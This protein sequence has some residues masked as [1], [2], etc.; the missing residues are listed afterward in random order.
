MSDDVDK[1]VNR[2]ASTNSVEMRSELS[3]YFLKEDPSMLKNDELNLDRLKVK[4]VRAMN[5][6]V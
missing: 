6:I 1:L 5:E 2:I 3:K 4:H